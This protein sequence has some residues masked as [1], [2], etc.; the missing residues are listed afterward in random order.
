MIIKQSKIIIVKFVKC[1]SNQKSV[2]VYKSHSNKKSNYTDY[3]RSIE[4]LSS[5]KCINI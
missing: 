3:F 2:L 1:K 5:E 4:K